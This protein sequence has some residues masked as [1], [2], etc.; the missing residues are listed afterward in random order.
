[1]NGLAHAQTNQTN[2]SS[3]HTDTRDTQFKQSGNVGNHAQFLLDESFLKSLDKGTVS[4]NGYQVVSNDDGKST[5]N[6][7]VFD[8]D[9]TVID[10]HSASSVRFSVANPSVSLQQMKHVYDASKLKHIPHT[11]DDA[12]Y[13]KDG[14]Y[15]Y[16]G[17]ATRLQFVVK[18][19]YV[20]TVTVGQV[21]PEG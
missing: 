15:V 20:S 3:V 7:H 9:I 10:S 17:D 5:Y 19:G 18:K 13:P 16:Q 11:N 12:Q 21:N 4:F 1:M 8:Q 6:K 14:T 2:M